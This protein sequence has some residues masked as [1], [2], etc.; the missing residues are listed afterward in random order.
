V[1]DL[2]QRL[3]AAL[4]HPEKQPWAANQPDS[5]RTSTEAVKA[6]S[7]ASALS[8]G[9]HRGPAPAGVRRAAVAVM[10]LQR[11]D[12][13]W[14]L[15]L[16][17]R[18]QNLRHHAG[19]VCFP[20][21]MIEADETPT[22]AALREFEEELGHRPTEPLMCGE[23]EPLYVY[24][25]NNLVFPVVFTATSLPDP[26]NPDPVEVESILEMPLEMLLAGPTR[27]T[28]SR[29][30]IR[31]QQPAGT[32]EFQSIAYQLSG[33]MIWGATAMLLARLANHLK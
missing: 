7:L 3:I 24:A 10:W 16:T 2:P 20:G 6:A 28:R 12:G 8:Y 1:Q 4:L 15:P 21:G 25:S 26:W 27:I 9:R 32:Y 17:L 31:D 29:Q 22:Q 11:E 14:W 30:I 19:Q 23:L 5:Q 13:S 18:P 33:H